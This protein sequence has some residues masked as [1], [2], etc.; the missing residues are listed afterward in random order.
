MQLNLPQILGLV[1][2]ALRSASPNLAVNNAL[3]NLGRVIVVTKANNSL[4]RIV[5]ELPDGVP[6]DLTGWEPKKPRKKGCKRC[7]P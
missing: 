5:I 1:D 7:P 2:R 6:P 4:R 3:R